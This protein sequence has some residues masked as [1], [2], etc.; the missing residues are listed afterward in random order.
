MIENQGG[1]VNAE[2]PTA[3]LGKGLPA[4]KKLIELKRGQIWG[5]KKDL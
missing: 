5:Y 3:M 4:S 1:G 2:T